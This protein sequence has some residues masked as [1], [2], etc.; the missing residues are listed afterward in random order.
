MA[1]GYSTFSEAPV[2]A[3]PFVF[4]PNVFAYPVGIQVTAELGEENVQ[5][6]QT[7]TGVQGTM[8][9]GTVTPNNK[10]NVS[11]V[12]ATGVIGN[13]TPNNKQNVAGV[14]A[15]GAIGTVLIVVNDLVVTNPLPIW[16]AVNTA[17]TPAWVEIDTSAGE[18]VWEDEEVPVN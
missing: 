16:S 7:P 18:T 1:F 13:V 10:Q 2:G 14:E 17:Q 15:T 12:A 4:D 6:K 5:V 3:L 11:G 8:A 9:T